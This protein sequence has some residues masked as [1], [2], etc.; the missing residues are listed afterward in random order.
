MLN[1]TRSLDWIP[2]SR[3][4]ASAWRLLSSDAGYIGLWA[5]RGVRGGMDGRGD[6][7]FRRGSKRLFRVK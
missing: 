4:N 1:E 6:A 7:R 3:A 2:P 5:G